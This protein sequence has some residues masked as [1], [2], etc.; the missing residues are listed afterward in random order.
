MKL[1]FRFISFSRFRQEYHKLSKP[2]IDSGPAARSYLEEKLKIIG[3]DIFQTEARAQLE[4]YEI[5]VSYF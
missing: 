1:L 2:E 5:V 3:Q 4:R